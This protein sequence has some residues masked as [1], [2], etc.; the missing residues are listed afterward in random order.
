MV[1]RAGFTWVTK[2]L[3]GEVK[4]PLVTTNRINM[5]GVAEQ[6]LA[7]KCAD[8]VSMARPMLADPEWVIKSREG[9]EAEINTCIGCNQAC[10]DH[11]FTR[12][13]ASCLVNPRACRETEMVFTKAENS[14][15]ICVVGGGPAGLS[16]A[17][18]AAARGHNVTLF[19]AADELGG[20]FRLARNIP[21]KEEFRETLRYFRKQIELT[22]VEL[23]L[24]HSRMWTS[25]AILMRLSLP[26][27]C[28]RA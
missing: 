20:Q 7:D 2:R 21:G 24:K 10:L 14:R 26:A 22:G 6:V 8:M 9:R 1:P 27:V 17:V 13:T 18:T 11:I 28:V 15:K 12:Q 23:R 4:I 5:P 16:C 25:C 3:M 19:E